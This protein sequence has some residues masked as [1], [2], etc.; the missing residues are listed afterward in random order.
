MCANVLHYDIKCNLFT[1]TL[2]TRDA[3][4]ESKTVKYVYYMKLDGTRDMYSH[5]LYRNSIAFDQEKGGVG[6]CPIIA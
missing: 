1:S 2:H 5:T 6:N 3:N 4:Y